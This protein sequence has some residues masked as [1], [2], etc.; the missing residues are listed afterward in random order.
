MAKVLRG[1]VE[2]FAAYPEAFADR[3]NPTAAELNDTDFV[4]IISCAVE[5]SYTLNPTSSDTDNSM[6]VCDTAQ[7]DTPTFSNYEASLDGF[8][9]KDL[10][11]NGFYNLF[12][13]LFKNKG[14]PYILGKRIGKA[15]G[16][17]FAPSDTISMYAVT[18]DNPVD[19]DDA[20][21]PVQMGARFKTD[22]WLN[23]E[24]EVAS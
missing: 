14:V 22:G 4:K 19:I 7:V 13:D 5:D 3:D 8:R 21:A 18:T 16:T 17:P 12:R 10:D 2:I 15:Q 24:Y 9:D 23:Q 11:A 20:G 6:S 1:N